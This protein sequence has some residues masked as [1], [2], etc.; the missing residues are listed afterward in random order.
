MKIYVSES[1][2]KYFVINGKKIYINT[3]MSKKEILSV[4]KA[5]KKNMRVKKP[6]V[7]NSAKAVVNI[8]Q[9]PRRRRRVNKKAFQS[10][11]DEKNRV[12][13]SGSTEQ[14]HPKDS[15]KED[16]INK[17]IN[18]KAGLENQLRLVGP[19]PM[20]QRQDPQLEYSV[21][22]RMYDMNQNPQ[23]HGYLSHPDPHVA[24]SGIKKL[25]K[26]YNLLP[27]FNHWVKNLKPKNKPPV[28]PQPQASSSSSGLNIQVDS[29][30]RQFKPP[31]PNDDDDLEPITI[32]EWNEM[33]PGVDLS[34]DDIEQLNTP[35][36]KK[37][38]QEEIKRP[39]PIEEEEDE[40]PDP[41]SIGEEYR[42]LDQM[43]PNVDPKTLD[44]NKRKKIIKLLRMK[45]LSFNK[46]PV[47]P[48]KDQKSYRDNFLEEIK[49]VSAQDLNEAFNE[50]MTKER[51]KR[52][53]LG[54]FAK[55][56][57]SAGKGKDGLYNDEIDKI[58][59]RFKDFKGC[60]MRDEIKKLLPYI[61][62][63]SR[64]AFIINTDTHDKPGQH[65]DAVYIDAR[66]GP[67]SSNSIEW[68]DSFGRPISS[69]IL[70]DCKLILKCLKPT[71]VLKLKENKVVHQSDNSSN[72]GWM[73]CKF[74]IDRFRGQSF[75][76]ATGYDDRI[77]I[78]HINK[79]EKE[80]EQLKNNSRPFNYIF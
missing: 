49:S 37:P 59:S 57:Q 43:Y 31:T 58:M 36:K 74:L 21:E 55:V 3:K 30:I 15:G 23:F 34:V 75:A 19:P 45:Y 40:I 6:Q 13:V 63:K 52:K 70:S 71:T 20:P 27:E 41:Q 77:K 47:N 50:V 79:D 17:L 76:S 26:Q 7:T 9:A 38:A 66:D 32:E 18:E 48:K 24:L 8:H 4:Y 33:Y 80:I 69:D 10:T 2:R 5:L 46:F 56:V 54:D 42:Q 73:C 61:E 64:V 78:N 16:E 11:I 35:I 12:S 14:R 62:P 53:R 72:C 22:D 68:F 28:P 25:S 51:G 29:P 39:T 67:E 65:W 1:G 44:F 60:V